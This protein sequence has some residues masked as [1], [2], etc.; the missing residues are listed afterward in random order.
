MTIILLDKL[1]SIDL[2]EYYKHIDI[3]LIKTGFNLI[4]H[5]TLN[6]K[7]HEKIKSI[8]CSIETFNIESLCFEWTKNYLNLVINYKL[9]IIKC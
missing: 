3:I 6:K 9:N 2:T 7:H 8:G 4:K 5:L 1:P